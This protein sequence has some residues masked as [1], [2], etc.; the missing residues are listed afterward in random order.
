MGVVGVKMKRCD[1]VLEKVGKRS[2]V[3]SEKEW[4]QNRTLRD[5]GGQRSQVRCS[6]VD[7]NELVS[8]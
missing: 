2:G 5:A 1:G 6:R 4:A 3:H 7:T 8:V